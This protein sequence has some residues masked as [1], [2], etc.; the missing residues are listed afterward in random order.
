MNQWRC[1]V[2]GKKFISEVKP[3]ACSVCGVEA[4][5]IVNEKNYNRPAKGISSQ[6]E[7]SFQKAMDLEVEATRI[8]NQFA[9]Q[10]RRENDKLTELFFQALAKNEKGHQVAIKFQLASRKV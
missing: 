3:V 5:Y 8:Y 10:A 2:C 6:S 1:L 7:T 9:E 4:K